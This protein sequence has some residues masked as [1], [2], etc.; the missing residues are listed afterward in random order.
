MHAHY[1]PIHASL[2]ITYLLFTLKL[3]YWVPVPAGVR[4]LLSMRYA[5]IRFVCAAPA[6]FTHYYTVSFHIASSARST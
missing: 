4:E 5:H 3:V 2:R 1:I 6:K